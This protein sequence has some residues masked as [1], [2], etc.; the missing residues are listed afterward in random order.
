VLYFAIQIQTQ[1]NHAEKEIKILLSIF[2]VFGKSLESKD[3]P[4][5]LYED[6]LRSVE[7]V[8]DYGLILVSVVKQ[9]I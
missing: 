3:N 2:K 1:F 7:N 8:A 5:L 6:Y 9:M 4:R